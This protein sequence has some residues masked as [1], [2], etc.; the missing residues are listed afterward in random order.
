M[1]S[2]LNKK[3]IQINTVLELEEDVLDLFPED[4]GE[5]EFKNIVETS[6]RYYI[7]N[8]CLGYKNKDK[9][10]LTIKSSHD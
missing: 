8:E 6:L 5:E 10:S 2:R 1:E 4:C 3:H 7:E 9:Y